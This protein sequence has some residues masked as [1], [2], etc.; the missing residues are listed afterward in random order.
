VEAPFHNIN[1]QVGVTV[2]LEIN[3][4]RRAVMNAAAVGSSW[5]WKGPKRW[6]WIMPALAGLYCFGVTITP[7]WRSGYYIAALRAFETLQESAESSMSLPFKRF[8]FYVHRFSPGWSQV[9]IRSLV[10][11]WGKASLAHV[12]ED[13]T[14]DLEGLSDLERARLNDQTNQWTTPEPS[15]NFRVAMQFEVRQAL[16][17]RDQ[18]TNWSLSDIWKQTASLPTA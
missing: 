9:W 7:T 18:A 3:E 5:R 4:A 14:L 6:Y 13:L 10:H 1:R 11:I 8:P 2:S 12:W 16:A 17:C 15:K